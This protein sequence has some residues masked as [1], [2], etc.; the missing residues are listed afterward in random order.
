MIMTL[1][2]RLAINHIVRI[3][4]NLTVKDAAKILKLMRGEYR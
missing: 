1:S 2:E 3:N 4:K